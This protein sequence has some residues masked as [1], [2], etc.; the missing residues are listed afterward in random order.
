MSGIFRERNNLKTALEYVRRLI[1]EYKDIGLSDKG[2]SMNMKLYWVIELFGSLLIS[3]ALLAGA[4]ARE[5][6]RGSFFRE[7]FPI[8]DDKNWLKHTIVSYNSGNLT[9]N[10]KDVN[11]SLMKPEERTY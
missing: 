11:M 9:V 7:D 10:Y 5:E 4:L 8:R 2:K 6:S 1:G 3:E